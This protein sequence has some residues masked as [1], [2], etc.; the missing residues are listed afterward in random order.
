LN[1][2]E[3][4]ESRRIRKCDQYKEQA[5][6]DITWKVIIAVNN[7]GKVIMKNVAFL[8]ILVTNM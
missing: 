5:L 3:E 8:Q 4:E 2:E 6:K 7:F 1:P